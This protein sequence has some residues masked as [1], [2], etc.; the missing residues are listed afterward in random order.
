MPGGEIMTVY[1]DKASFFQVKTEMSVAQM[2]M[3]MEIETYL[4]DY[5]DFNGLKL[6]KTTTTYA[7]GTEMAMMMIDK[8]E[9]NVPMDDKI[10]KLK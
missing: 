6:P 10:F 7:N 9:L 4:A 3:E 5:T 2:G 1:I 8:V